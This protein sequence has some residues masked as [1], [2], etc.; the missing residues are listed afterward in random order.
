MGGVHR[1]CFL[2][3]RTIID[4]AAQVLHQTYLAL[5]KGDLPPKDFNRGLLLLLPKKDTGLIADTRPLGVNNTDNRILARVTVNM[6][7]P[8]VEQFIDPEQEAFVPAKH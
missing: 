6:L 5:S 1:S 8:A 7:A 2:A 3:Y 4:T